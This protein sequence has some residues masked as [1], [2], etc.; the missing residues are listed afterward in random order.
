MEHPEV[1]GFPSPLEDLG[2]TS[3][4]PS[5]DPRPDHLTSSVMKNV[6]AHSIRSSHLSKSLSLQGTPS[7]SY[8]ARCQTSRNKHQSRPTK[9]DARQK[10][11]YKFI[12]IQYNPRA[13]LR[14]P[15]VRHSRHALHARRLIGCHTPKPK[16]ACRTRIKFPR[17][18]NCR[19][20]GHLRPDTRLE[21]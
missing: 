7:F 2:E 4:R 15:Y 21:R 3:K 6:Q 8:T 16:P 9:S 12:E 14:T 13:P 1:P 20:K 19:Q 18:S 11:R 5:P 17:L 10:G